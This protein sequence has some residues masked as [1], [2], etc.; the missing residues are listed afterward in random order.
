LKRADPSLGVAHGAC[1]LVRGDV[2]REIDGHRLVRKEMFEDT[3]LAQA[4]RASGHRSECLDG[5]DVVRVRMYQS[6]RGIWTGFLKNF[7][8]AF[9]SAASFWLFMLLHTAVFFAPFV[10]LAVGLMGGNVPV[11]IITAAASV[12]AMRFALALRFG[13]PLWSAVLHPLGEAVL[14]A[15]GLRSWWMCRSGAGVEWK[16][17][18]YMT[19]ESNTER[20][21]DERS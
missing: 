21:G 17:R 13:H 19:A 4:W 7:R 8:P 16:G 20:T 14:I 9:R 1:I 10:V 3:R 5:Q 18:R 2:Y 11:A 12:L 6:F 15:C